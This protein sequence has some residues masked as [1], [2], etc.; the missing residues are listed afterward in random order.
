MKKDDMDDPCVRDENVL[1]CVS[2]HIL[3]LWDVII[4]TNW[5]RCVLDFCIISYN[6]MWTNNYLHIKLLLKT[7]VKDLPKFY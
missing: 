1:D 5:V 2:I 3:V 4:G 6:L 7:K